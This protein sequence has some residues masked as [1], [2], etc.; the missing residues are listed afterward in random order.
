MPSYKTDV[1]DT[2]ELETELKQIKY[3]L[4]RTSGHQVGCVR[5]D[6]EDWSSA[7]ARYE[8]IQKVLDY[9]RSLN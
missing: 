6:P 9:R 7:V 3:Y 8:Y 5:G 2:T 1:S 4:K